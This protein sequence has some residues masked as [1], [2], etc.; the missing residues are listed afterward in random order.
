MLVFSSVTSHRL[1]VLVVMTRLFQNFGLN[2]LAESLSRP[3]MSVQRLLKPMFSEIC[4]I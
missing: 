1:F 2:C 3:L 4:L